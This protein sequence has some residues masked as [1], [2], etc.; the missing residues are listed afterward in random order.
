MG[1]EGAMGPMGP[2]G[3]TGDMGLMGPPGRG[4]SVLL[5]SVIPAGN[6][7]GLDGFSYFVVPT[8]AVA[9]EGDG[10]FL[11]PSECFYPKLRVVAQAGISASY[12]FTLLR[13]NGPQN[14]AGEGIANVSCTVDGDDNVCTSWAEMT[15]AE[16]DG[17]SI[18]MD[19]NAVGAT[20]SAIAVSLSC[21]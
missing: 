9:S 19:G 21:R 16:D 8:D 20:T 6:G 1:P 14:T 10:I 7:S 5:N 4:T 15:I 12:T 2:Q 11:A 3:L 13:Y 17:F 18:R